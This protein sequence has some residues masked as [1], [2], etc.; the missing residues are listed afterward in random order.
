MMSRRHL[1]YAIAAVAAAGVLATV[2]LLGGGGG[3]AEPGK[4]A[5]TLPHE[6]L[7]PPRA[8]LAS[9]R[10]RPAAINFWASWCE[11]CREEAAGFERLARRLHGRAAL[12]GVDWEDDR[13][14]AL[15]FVHR[16]GWSFPVL[17]APRGSD[18][19]RYGVI[20]LPT[21]VVLDPDGRVATILRGPQSAAALARALG[22]SPRSRRPSPAG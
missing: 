11:P 13:A 5:P 17:R 8:T 12:V 15:G 3:G 1:A 10:G 4:R 16:Y 20:G 18:G 7:V 2:A 19:A 9:L 6:V 22:V 14:A 21:T